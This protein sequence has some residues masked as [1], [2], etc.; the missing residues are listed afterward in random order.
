M[1]LI[2]PQST[3]TLASRRWL[4]HFTWED[5]PLNQDVDG[6]KA[7]FNGPRQHVLQILDTVGMRPLSLEN[8]TL[9][10]ARCLV[11]Q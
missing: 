11:R 5:Q 1:M 2:Y 3:D 4:V 8:F 6:S 10:I 9:L 7:I